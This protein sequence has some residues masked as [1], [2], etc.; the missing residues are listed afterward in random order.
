MKIHPENEAGSNKDTQFRANW[1]WRTRR[2]PKFITAQY[3]L[4]ESSDFSFDVWFSGDFFRPTT[5]IRRTTRC[6]S[7]KPG[8]AFH[9][10]AKDKS[11]D[12]ESLDASLSGTILLSEL[13]WVMQEGVFNNVWSKSCLKLCPNR[14]LVSPSTDFPTDKLNS[15]ASQARC[16]LS[17][18]LDQTY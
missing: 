18:F 13:D 7:L 1:K 4:A 5:F 15:F 9:F 8:A 3:S 12:N 10:S 17:W 16:R 2:K 6:N 11:S 14:S